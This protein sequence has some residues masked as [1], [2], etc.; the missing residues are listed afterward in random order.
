[1]NLINLV[2]EL[3]K[4]YGFDKE[5]ALILTGITNISKSSSSNIINNNS[6]SKI[7]DQIKPFDGII[8]SNCCKA[9]VYNHGLYTQCNV[10][11]KQEFC[12]S[13][14]KRLKYGHINTRKNYPVGS[15]IL[16]NGKKEIPYQK[17]KKRLDKKSKNDKNSR[18]L[19]DDSDDDIELERNISKVINPRGRPKQDAKNI[20]ILMDSEE[21]NDKEDNIEEILV[22]RQI[23]DNEEYLVS[24][25]NIIFD[26]KTFNMLG[27]LVLGKKIEIK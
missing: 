1:M 15:Y 9:V 4:L 11:T 14:C 7:S 20:N 24:E 22:R 2:E 13:L 18:I 5:E 17:V 6:S 10:V 19:V 25:D 23:I 16:E 12:S 3:S 8:K 26:P 21:D 27:R